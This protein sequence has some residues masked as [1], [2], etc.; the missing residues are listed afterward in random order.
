MGLI[1]HWYSYMSSTLSI[2]FDQIKYIFHCIC[3]WF[4]VV[5][6]YKC[7]KMHNSLGY[8]I[9]IEY[10][11]YTARCSR[12]TLPTAMVS[13]HFRLCSQYWHVN[14]CAF[15]SVLEVIQSSNSTMPNPLT[16]RSGKNNNKQQLELLMYSLTLCIELW[17]A[18]VLKMLIAVGLVVTKSEI[19]LLLLGYEI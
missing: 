18:C 11:F 12:R 10:N 1:S 17:V 9:Q 2:T 19:L 13:S 7:I 16:K 8:V 3:C 15:E 4:M 6:L 5:F 14:I